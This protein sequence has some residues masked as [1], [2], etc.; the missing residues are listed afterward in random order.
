MSKCRGN[1]VG[2][3][4]S[5]HALKA[6]LES[7]LRVGSALVHMYPKSGSIVGDEQGLTCCILIK[8]VFLVGKGLSR[9]CAIHDT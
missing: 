6:E 4:G 1:G 8:P 5:S 3:G 2:E 7:D 9:D